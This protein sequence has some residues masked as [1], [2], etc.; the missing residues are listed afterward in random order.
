MNDGE[1][2]IEGQKHRHIPNSIRQDALDL[3]ACSQ[4]SVDLFSVVFCRESDAVRKLFGWLARD[5]ERVQ[6][7]T[8]IGKEILN[9]T[10]NDI[11]Q[12]L[13]N[14]NYKT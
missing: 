9:N 12:F 13:K 1:R 7:L 2:Q 10:Y 3:V 14:E 6:K 5:Q 4:D 8:K 11:D